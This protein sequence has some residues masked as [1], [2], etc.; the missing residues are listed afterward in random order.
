[1]TLWQENL[2]RLIRVIDEKL[3]KVEPVDTT[4]CDAFRRRRAQVE[5]VLGEMATEEGAYYRL[6]S[7]N[8]FRLAGL[9]T[10][11]TGGAEGL[12]RNWQNAARRK[13]GAAA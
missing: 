13:L 4:D 10:T 12:L 2:T 3:S 6:G 9:A 1:M 7:E 5:A 11:C 8:R